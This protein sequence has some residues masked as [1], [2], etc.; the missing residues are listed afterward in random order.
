M[1]GRTLQFLPTAKDREG[2]LPWV[3]GVMLFLCALAVSS[4]LAINSGVEQWS[5][6]LSTNVTVQII[7]ADQAERDRQTTA[8]L[9]LL[10]ATPGIASATVLATA[11]VMALVSPWLGELPI[12]AELPIP[13]LIDV[14]LEP[15]ANMNMQALGERLTATAPGAVL[16]D[17]QA[18]LSQV[19]D[20]AAIIEIVMAAIVLMVILS[21]IAIVIFGCRA[22]LAT[23]AE[24][25]EIMHLMGSDDNVI[26]RA[27]DMKYLMHGIKGG[28]LG[29]ALAGMTLW[30]TA[31]LAAELGQGLVFAALPQGGHELWL[32]V[33][34]FAAAALTMITARLT[35]RHALQEMM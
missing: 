4:A 12:D 11:D 13:N 24:S 20:L 25:I 31:H 2:L 21:T 26:C 23:H 28:I 15:G 9:R 17:H 5:K 6:D 27:F 22:G 7:V 34:P 18:W 10:D 29:V 32:L 30:L 14:A 33:L 3:I 35:V 19:L 1:W 16:D 8:A